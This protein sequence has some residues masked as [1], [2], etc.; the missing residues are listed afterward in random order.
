MQ[1]A[2]YCPDRHFLY[3]G[4]TPDQAGVGGGL[5]VRIRIAAAL[6]RRGHR[7]SVICNC[8]REIVHR[9]V[10]YRPLDQADRI[11]ADVLVMHSSGGA[12]DLT[13]LL[14]VSLDVKIR[15]FLLSGPD[16]ARNVHAL[17]P[18]AIYVCSNY[19]RTEML[20]SGTFTRNLFVTHY[21]VNRWNWIS[22]GGGLAGFRSVAGIFRPARNPGRLIYSSHPSKGFDAARE[23]AR[24]LHKRDARFQLHYFGGSRLWGSS[25]AEEVP[26]PEPCICYRGLINQ[27]RLASEYKRSS[28]L[29]QLQTRPEPFGIVVV[30]AMAAGCLVVASQV[31]AFPE[32]IEHGENGFLVDGDPSS[33]ETLDAAADL[34]RNVSQ[35]PPLADKIRHRALATPF[36]WNTLAEVWEAHLK[37]LMDQKGTHNLEADWARCLAC[38]GTSLVLADGYH[39]TACGYFA[40]KCRWG[41]PI[42]NNNT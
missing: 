2:I 15:V 39:C 36:D 41:S 19:I 11:Q 18:D 9:G 29:V 40:R 10:L 27:R 12:I 35:N 28:F 23:I 32:L 13:P 42:D 8:P 5:T 7:V 14:S 16:V 34:I 21:G 37:W 6:A 30:E 38:G 22:G 26:P 17:N 33:P 20:R 24:R 4:T 3:D 31:G 25:V 1:I